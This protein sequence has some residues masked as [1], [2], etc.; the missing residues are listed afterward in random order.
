MNQQVKTKVQNCTVRQSTDK[1]A[2]ASP[3]PLQPVEFPTRPWV[4]LGM[5]II[6][7]FERAPA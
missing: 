1:P 3:A 2:K 5:D 4:K 7:P 6:G